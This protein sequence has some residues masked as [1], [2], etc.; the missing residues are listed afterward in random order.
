M[1][2]TV[3]SVLIARRDARLRSSTSS[4]RCDAGLPAGDDP[5]DG[6]TLEWATSSPPPR[7]NFDALPPM[8]SFA[9]LLDARERAGAGPVTRAAVALATW[10][11]WLMVLALVLAFW[12]P[13]DLPRFLLGAAAL[14]ALVIAGVALALPDAARDRPLPDESVA[15]VLVAV[16]VATMMLGVVAGLWL[17][18]IGVGLTVTGLAGV[19][20]ELSAQRR[21]GRG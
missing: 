15:T 4:S 16:G 7:H 9:P 5:W 11:A 13:D 3:G 6:Q 14:G 8:R 18:L 20:R 12:T 2:A 21:A 10:G 17:T 1:L 19:V